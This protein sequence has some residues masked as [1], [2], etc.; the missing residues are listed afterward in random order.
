MLYLK[1]HISLG[2]RKNEYKIEDIKSIRSY[3]YVEPTSD[4]N[5]FGYDYPTDRRSGT[6]AVFLKNGERHY[7]PA[8]NW[9]IEF[10]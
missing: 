7:Y 8:S 4:R 5:F 10:N 6:I 1:E 2:N 3:A 9:Q